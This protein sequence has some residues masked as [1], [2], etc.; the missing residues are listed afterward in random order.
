[1]F[2][3]L[4]GTL[5]ILLCAAAMAGAVEAASPPLDLRAVCLLTRQHNPALA[6]AAAEAAQAA[7]EQRKTQAGLLPRLTAKSSYSHISEPTFFGLTPILASNT[8]INRIELTQPIY[9]GGQLQAAV[10]AAAYGRSAA[11]QARAAVEG[12]V[13]TEAAGAYF[14]AL[15][16]KAAVGVAESSFNSLNSNYDAAQKLFAA[17]VVTNSDVLRAEVALTGA[18]D[19][20]I[21]ANNNSATALAALKAAIGLLQEATIELAA[22]EPAPL[23]DP[24][25]LPAETR[26]EVAAAQFGVKAADAQLSGARGAS[27]P[28][29]GLFADYQNQ[30]TGAEFPRLSDTAMV[31]LQLQFN[32]FDGGQTKAEVAAAKAA[33]DRAASDLDEIKQQTEFQLQASRL[34]LASARERV[35]ALAT[36]V[37][38]A[39]ESYRVVSIGYQ[40]GVNVLTDVLSVESMLTQARISRLNADY[41]LKIAEL[42]LLLALGQTKALT[43]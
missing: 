17:G 19:Q 39:E 23:A 16:A 21:A 33:A 29:L 2:I 8:F 35:S 18:K 9:S 24:T 1:M 34:A 42:N 22:E 5:G 6:G 28:S 40:E 15:Q 43:D 26:G 3:K 27:R 14:R 4:M 20:L 32:L 41:D 7:A 38:S 25:Q 31:G 11:E 36:Q 37:K 12:Q 10:K 13:L 30:P